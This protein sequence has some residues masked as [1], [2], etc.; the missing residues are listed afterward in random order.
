MINLLTKKLDNPYTGAI[1]SFRNGTKTVVAAIGSDIDGD[2]AAVK[3]LGS[4]ANVYF[5]GTA[6]K[7]R[8]VI[9]WNDLTAIGVY[10]ILHNSENIPYYH[11]NTPQ[12]GNITEKILNG[13]TYDVAIRLVNTTNANPTTLRVKNVNSDFS[14][15]YRNTLASGNTRPV[16]MS[17]GLFNDLVMWEGE[18]TGNNFNN[19]GLA[20]QLAE[21]GRDTWEIEVTGGPIA[22]N[23]SAPNYD[24]NTL[25]DN[26]WTASLAAIQYYTGKI[27]MDYIGF[28][29]GCRTA[30]TGL[31]RYQTN[32]ISNIAWVQNLMTGNYQ[33]VN[34]QSNSG[35]NLVHTF[36]GVGC[37][38][39]FE[40]SSYLIEQVNQHPNSVSQ[41]QAR[42]NWHPDRDDIA[43]RLIL[44]GLF[45]R[46]LEAGNPISLN[47]WSHYNNL[48]L[49]SNDSQP[50]NFNV[51]RSVIIYGYG[52]LISTFGNEQDDGMVTVNDNIAIANNIN[53][54]N[55]DDRLSYRDN[56]MAITDDLNIK[57]RIMVFLLND[58]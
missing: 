54:T 5:S 35:A 47:L 52:G 43:Q 57:R 1:C 41:L 33:L 19:K 8:I 36:V 17:G 21:T 20:K 14:P 40:G 23:L 26:Y 31:E 42:Q 7:P 34:L 15:I 38:G 22:D 39:A 25:V 24:Y 48:I 32:P 2:I 16:V 44:I 45:G 46:V 29:N 58:N 27:T 3:K 11:V 49:L 37:P 51:N 50:G 53:S 13:N 55:L 9:D 12:F 30:L 28:S 18:Y 10:D 4:A 6:V 56:H